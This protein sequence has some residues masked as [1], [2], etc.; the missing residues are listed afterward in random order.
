M[1][2]NKGV[3]QIYAL[4]TPFIRPLKS[5]FEGYTVLR[6]TQVIQ[7]KKVRCLMYYIGVAIFIGLMSVLFMF[8][9][10]FGAFLDIPSLIVI[11]GLSLPIVMASGLFNDFLNGFKM[12]AEKVNSFS[13]VESKRILSAVK[14]M[15]K[16][17]LLSGI[18]G[19]LSGF[20][21][22]MSMYTADV[23]TE[24]LVKSC[25]VACI[26]LIYALVFTFIL[27]PIEAKAKAVIA[28]LE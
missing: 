15:I 26:T 10:T 6:I 8:S 5:T 18:I 14:L 24:M 21:S 17:I 13:L 2:E 16:A 25:G 20:I 9:S 3:F 11:V 12:M 7:S 27:L 4:N 28:S 22:I 23:S 1:E 19:T